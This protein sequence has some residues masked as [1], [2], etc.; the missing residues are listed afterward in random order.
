MLLIHEK[1][2]QKA[3]DGRKGNR[4]FLEI[5]KDKHFDEERKRNFLKFGE[6]VIVSL[7]NFIF[8]GVNL[9]STTTEQENRFRIE[10]KNS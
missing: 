4:K 1:S 3:A 6:S 9:A 2:F 7:D 8:L 10:G 5:F